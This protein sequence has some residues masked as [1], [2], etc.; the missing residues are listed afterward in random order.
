MGFEVFAAQESEDDEDEEEVEEEEDDDDDELSSEPAGD[1]GR[2]FS[3]LRQIA[4][5]AFGGLG[6]APSKRT[7]ALFV[8]DVRAV[9]SALGALPR[10]C[11]ATF[12]EASI[13]G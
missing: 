8:E 3:G 13:F 9:L 1:A 7:T 6:F 10:R 4:E 2:V 11:L 12:L 5:S